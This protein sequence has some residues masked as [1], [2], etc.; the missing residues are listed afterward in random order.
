MGTSREHNSQVATDVA[1]ARYVQRD[2]PRV[3]TPQSPS[4][5]ALRRLELNTIRAGHENAGFLSASRGYLPIGNPL[6]A[7]DPAYAE[8]D[9]IAA[10]LPQLYRELSVRKRI[11]AMPVL[12]ATA[13]RLDGRQVLRACALLAIL[14]HAYWYVDSRPPLALPPQLRLPWAQLRKRL[15]RTQEVISYIDL[16]VYN[17]RVRDASLPNPLLVENL[18]LL[19]PTIG[20]QEERVF[21]MTQ[22]EILGRTAAVPKLVASAQ[23]AALRDD[24]TELEAA[25]TGI[26]DA[27]SGVVNVSLPKINPNPYGR[28]HVDPVLWAKTVAPFAVPI[29]RGDQGPS[30]TSSPLFNTLDLFFGRKDYES[31]LGREIKALRGHYPRAWQVF[32]GALS[33]VDVA[34]YVELKGSQSLKSAFREAFELYAGETGFLGRHRMKVYGYLELA[35]KVGRSV[36]I[37]GFGG[38]FTDRT[39]DQVDGEL[40]RSQAERTKEA[41]ESVHRARVIDASPSAHDAPAALRRVTLDVSEAAVRYRGGDRCLILP[42]NDPGVV[43]RTL[44]ALG[45][46]GDEPIGLTDEWRAHAKDRVELAGKTQLTIRELLLYGAIR[47]VSPRLAEALHARTQSTFLFDTIVRG[48]TERWELWEL[49]EELRRRGHDSH[50]LWQQ[51]GV[52]CSELLARLVPP[53]R[54]R[55]YSVS[56]APENPLGRGEHNIQLTVGQLRYPAASGC[57][58]GQPSMGGCPHPSAMR[59]GTASTFLARAHVTKREVPFRIQHPDVF[60]LPEHAET[61]I[62]MFAGGSGVAPFRA[63]LQ[64]R[65]RSARPGLT[66]LFLS[67][68]SPDDFLYDDEFATLLASGILSLQVAFTREGAR[69]GLGENGRLALTRDRTPGST[70]RIA[71]LMLS[72]CNQARLWQL[73]RPMEQGGK[74]AVFYVCGRSGFAD[75]VTRTLKQIFRPHVES[76]EAASKHLYQMVGDHRMLME[77]HTDAKPLDEAPRLFD[78]SEIARHNDTR[79]GWWVV[80]DRVVYDLTEFVELHPGGRR[81]VQAYA[82]MDA[83]HGFARAHYGR[84]DVDAMRET[85][86]IGMVRTPVFDDYVVQVEG[87]NGQVAVDCG[88]AYRAFA[89]ALQLVVEMQN[90]LYADQSLQHAI[91]HEPSE[92][93]PDVRTRDPYKQ[94]RAIE[95][96]RRFLKNYFEVLTQRTLPELWRISHG[97]FYAEQPVEQL[98][99]MLDDLLHTPFAEQVTSL[100]QHAFDQFEAFRAQGA[101]FTLVEAFEA[102]DD[103]FLNEMKHTL[104]LALREFEVHGADVRSLGS[105]RVRRACLRMAGVVRQYFR[106]AVMRMPERESLCRHALAEP[107]SA[108]PPPTLQRMHTGTYW[109]FEEDPLQRLAV[110]RRTPVVVGSL[111]ELVAENERVLRCL[112]VDHNRYG[113]VVDTRQAR[114]RNDVFFED[115][116]A[117]LRRELV[118]QFQRTAV[119]LESSIGELQVSRIERDERRQSIATRSESAAFKFAQ[120]AS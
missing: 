79:N 80:I 87:P 20:N 23:G 44:S 15:G 64:E 40:A 24:E 91:P 19:F 56:S 29:H 113:L 98:P 115:A 7:L 12:P 52:E 43:E 21:Y 16:I 10:E 6:Q 111:E 81:V 35:F 5:A 105:T 42:E 30:G 103:W 101:L 76:D 73:A 100:A 51:S 67:V 118:G 94:L 117:K 74:G 37:G 86:R 68:R 93:M 104:T 107:T 120:G 31:F 13:D 110:L 89:R 78:V 82:G 8:W 59:Q 61:P 36:T 46:R 71:D 92:R 34:G 88:A 28:T 27:L 60:R 53:Q 58:M 25:L 85:Y 11:D 55:V 102:L 69:V 63:F 57:P 75:S 72:P 90:A 18:E 2:E 32:L 41:P 106:R 47:P 3:R 38:V 39:W 66:M 77:I 50:T 33:E 14:S 9:A 48:V 62:V 4:E 70:Q 116:M 96:H 95:T 99:R 108:E 119:L 84:A 49:L 45:A 1:R 109:V 26:I 17:W 97:L 65:A 83:T 54:F 112:R 22:L 114:M